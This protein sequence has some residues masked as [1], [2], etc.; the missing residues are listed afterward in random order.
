MAENEI[1]RLQSRARDFAI[2]RDWEQFHLPRSLVLALTG[3]VGELSELFQW[4]SDAGVP[5]WINVP[6]N[7]S[8]LEEE[9]AD[10]FL[11]LLRLAEVT[12]VDLSAATEAKL[13]LNAKKYPVDRARGTAAKYTE[14][15]NSQDGN[16]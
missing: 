6:E 9:M 3:E 4:V 2:E 10:V 12:G 15:R 7:R 11:Y 1:E 13:E 8:R 16:S 5:A 14:L